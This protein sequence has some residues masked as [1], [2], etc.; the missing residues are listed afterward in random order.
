MEL[1]AHHGPKHNGNGRRRSARRRFDD[2]ICLAPFRAINGAKLRLRG[3]ASSVKEAALATGSCPPYVVAGIV[4]LQS[5]DV[6]LIA[7]VLAGRVGLL[8]A[9]RRV[10]QVTQLI[11]AY[12]KA[13][14]ADRVAF[15]RIIGP[16]ALFDDT[17]VPAI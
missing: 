16:T 15:A 7:E 11:V 4:L 5:N 17:L 2:D 3:D 1:L 8:E 12:R 9:A 13:T 6:T 14:A 10:K